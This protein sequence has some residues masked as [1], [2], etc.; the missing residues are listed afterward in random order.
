MRPRAR[1]RLQLLGLAA[2]C[3]AVA[4]AGTGPA[5]VGAAKIVVLTV[6]KTGTGSGRVTSLPPGIDCGSSCA[7]SFQD[8]T[9]V[10]LLANASADS[11]FIGWGGACTGAQTSCTLVMDAPK[12]V[13]A[14]FDSILPPVKGPPVVGKT[15]NVAPVAGKVLVKLPNRRGFVRLNRASSIPVGS[16]VDTSTG[17]VGLTSALRAGALNHARFYSGLFQIRQKRRRGAVTELALRASL[18]GCASFQPQSLQA[19]RKRRRLW[20]SGKGRF[21]TRGRYSSA[22]VRGTKWLV[23]DRC[24]GTLTRVVHGVVAVRDFRRGVT[25]LVPAGGSYFAAA[26]PRR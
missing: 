21:R 14:R 9:Q 26:K 17:T 2:A 23:E 5:A 4:S 10:T 12:A 1:R 24:D 15:A 13:T 20:G 6:S 19:K 11:I 8:G 16:L 22:S 3:L 25:V 7:A 18:T